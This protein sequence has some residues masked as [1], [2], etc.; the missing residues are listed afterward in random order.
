MPGRFD[1]HPRKYTLGALLDG[2]WLVAT[3]LAIWGSACWMIVG[4]AFIRGPAL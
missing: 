1:R 2:V 4:V 3:L